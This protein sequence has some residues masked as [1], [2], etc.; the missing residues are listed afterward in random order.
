MLFSGIEVPRHVNI[1]DSDLPL[2]E[3]VAGQHGESPQTYMSA[4]LGLVSVW[5]FM[6]K[7]CNL[8]P[9]FAQGI[10]DLPNNSVEVFDIHD[11]CQDTVRLF[12]E[13]QQL[14]AELGMP[15]VD[16]FSTAGTFNL[17]TTGTDENIRL[18]AGFYDL[19]VKSLLS[20]AVDLRHNILSRQQMGHIYAFSPDG[21]DW[22]E[23][24]L[25][26]APDL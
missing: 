22:L 9:D 7:K 11:M 2:L 19:S 17:S 25:S 4:S 10:I 26:T 15:S 20:L 6:I 1:P 12:E 5:G 13:R 24:R 21:Q 18:A 8:S 16:D 14:A 23:A 3:H